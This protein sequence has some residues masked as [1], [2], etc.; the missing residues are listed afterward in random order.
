M[1]INERGTKCLTSQPIRKWS[2]QKKQRDVALTAAATA[3]IHC[4]PAGW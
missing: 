1:T 2:G 4:D 3:M